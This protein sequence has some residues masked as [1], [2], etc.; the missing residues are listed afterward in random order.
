[1][2]QPGESPPHNP[3]RANNFEGGEL[4]DLYAF[5]VLLY[6]A[7]TDGYPFNPELPP[8]R[9]A[10]VIRLRVPRAPHRINPKVP[11]SLGAIA[12][13]LLEKRPED[14]FPSAEALHQALWEPCC[15]RPVAASRSNSKTTRLPI[16]SQGGPGPD[17]SH[18]GPAEGLRGAPVLRGLLCQR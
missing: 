9:L 3:T 12:M 4:A 5:G 1:M 2:K 16:V 18:P 10:A 14:R 13:R 8:E 15:G 11:L 17:D 6:S 7:L